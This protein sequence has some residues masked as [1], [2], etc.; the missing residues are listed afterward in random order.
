[1]TGDRKGS[2]A[3]ASI[4]LTITMTSAR[5]ILSTGR[6][7]P[8]LPLIQPMAAARSMSFSDQRQNDFTD[9][10][11]GDW[12]N[13]AIST[14]TKAGILKGYEDGTFKP[15]Q[16]ISRE[17]M[18]VSRFLHVGVPP[19]VGRVVREGLHVGQPPPLGG[20]G[21]IPGVT[22]AGFPL[23]CQPSG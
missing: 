22:W 10:K 20:G 3:S 12:Y 13:N 9:V 19:H 21:G 14:C 15:N 1:M 16:T 18:D 17:L 5:V 7:R 11:K 6:N 2:D 23:R 4:R 8:L